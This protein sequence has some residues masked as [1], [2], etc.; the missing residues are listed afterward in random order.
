MDVS[1]EDTEA[2]LHPGAGIVEP[3]QPD[4]DF[5]L[6]MLPVWARKVAM[7]RPSVAQQAGSNS[8]ATPMTTSSSRTA[9]GKWAEVRVK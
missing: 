2:V 9:E 3:M 5:R 8:S 1:A 4:F 6:S 7:S